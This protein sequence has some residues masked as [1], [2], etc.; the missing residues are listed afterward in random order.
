M[1]VN[2]KKLQAG[3]Y[4]AYQPVPTGPQQQT[5]QAPQQ[6]QQGQGEDIESY[7]DPGIMKRML[8]KGITTDVM[9]YSSQLQSAYQQYQYMSDFQKNSY[10]GR[11]IRMMLKGD[12]GQLNALVR[13]KTDF[14]NSV[15]D[16]K[17]ND[18]LGELAT[19][20]NGMVVRDNDSGKVTQ[21]G[22]AEYAQNKNKYSA[23]T[24]AQLAEQREYNNALVGNSNVFGILSGAKG[25]S[26]VQ[27]EVYK[28]VG[29][30]GRSST[31]VANGT[32][33][34]NEAENMNQLAEAA[35][36][37]AF[38]I[39]TGHSEESNAPQIQA[40]KQTLWMNLSS[41]AKATLRARAATMTAK[42]EE[43]DGIAYK[44]MA[45]LLDPHT[46]TKNTTTF[47]ET[48]TK[49]GKAAAKEQTA[50]WGL[51]GQAASGDNNTIPLTQIA[52]NGVKIDG[53]AS[54]IPTEA[55][56]AKDGSKIRLADASKLGNL[57]YVSQAFTANGDKVNPNLTSITGDA[58][59]TELPFTDDG[60]GDYK[61]DYE[62]AKKFAQFQDAKQQLGLKYSNPDDLQKIQ[63]L[64]EKFGVHNMATKKFIVANAS[65]IDNSYFSSR[66]EDFYKKLDGADK[67]NAQNIINPTGAGTTMFKVLHND[68]H[69]HLIFI[70]MKSIKNWNSMDGNDALIPK[71]SYYVRNGYGQG[72][73]S[74][75][76]QGRPMQEINT[77]SDYL[78]QK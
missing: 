41:G 20:N 7:M 30:I 40:A 60:N 66:D 39:K 70:P 59:T 63:E 3:G 54:A 17:A 11:Q 64:K 48:L 15:Q 51:Y 5:Q 65:S 8:G 52:P 22:F 21:V 73:S 37:G 10:Q 69:Q 45:S 2:I 44:L 26:K 67:E 75:S 72:D 33:Q 68:V 36:T 25:M 1:E 13:S 18:A 74:F 16:A 31:T 23:L 47:D 35:K 53:F 6:P 78:N 46:E 24:N 50:P 38:K 62:G 19:T 9:Q 14:D 49:G 56:T 77:S 32:F 4:I 71:E 27:E 28:I 34:S 58:Y 61:I 55:Y 76:P 43:I 12:F 42:P 57:G 29:S